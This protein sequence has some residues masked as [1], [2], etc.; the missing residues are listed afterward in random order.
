VVWTKQLLEDE[1]DP[2]T[3]EETH[4]VVRVVKV[5]GMNH[6]VHKNKN[7]QSFFIFC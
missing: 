7:Q 2:V 5:S 3:E 4:R 1:K 6:S